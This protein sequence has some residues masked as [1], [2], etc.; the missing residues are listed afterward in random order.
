MLYEQGN[1]QQAV[2][3]AESM[4]AI[5]GTRDWLLTDVLEGEALEAHLNQ[6]VC[7]LAVHMSI[8][9][10]KMK[11]NGFSMDALRENT[12][13]RHQLDEIMRTICG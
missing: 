1:R 9:L 10:E 7:Q 5:P 2:A 6:T 8:V 12:R 3:L 4:Q 13:L 11:D